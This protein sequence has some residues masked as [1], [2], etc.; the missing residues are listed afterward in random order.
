MTILYW[1]QR[2]TLCNVI[3]E[4]PLALEEQRERIRIL[5]WASGQIEGYAKLDGTKSFCS[6]LT[7][8]A[9]LLKHLFKESITVELCEEDCPENNLEHTILPWWTLK[10]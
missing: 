4:R 3:N 6:Y 5:F 7:S 2:K 10:P 9:N 1:K 8:I